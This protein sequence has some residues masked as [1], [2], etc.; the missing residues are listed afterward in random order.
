[1]RSQIYFLE[2]QRFIARVRAI[3]VLKSREHVSEGTK[4]IEH[5]DGVAGALGIHILELK[6]S[7]LGV[8]RLKV[9]F[10]EGQYVSLAV[11]VRR[12]EV[13]LNDCIDKGG[14]WEVGYAESS[15]GVDSN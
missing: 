3:I 12:L 15:I 1:V 5:E 7:G 8:W 13:S 11:E 14:P 2:A 4:F 6:E 10:Y 9:V